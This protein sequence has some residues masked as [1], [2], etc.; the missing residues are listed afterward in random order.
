MSWTLGVVRSFLVSLLLSKPCGGILSCSDCGV[1][2]D[3]KGRSPFDQM[4][5][6]YH[7]NSTCKQRE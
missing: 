7:C 1:F 5:H 3:G 4:L 6:V 2:A